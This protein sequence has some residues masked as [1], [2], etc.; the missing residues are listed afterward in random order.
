MRDNIV[1]RSAVAVL[2]VGYLLVGVVR[3]RVLE[4]HVPGVQEAGQETET[5]EGEV[6][7]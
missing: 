5:A 3:I 1:C 4:D 2:A 7:E 6:D